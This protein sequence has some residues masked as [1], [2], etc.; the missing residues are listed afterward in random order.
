MDGR[1]MENQIGILSNSASPLFSIDT[2]IQKL[3]V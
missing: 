3:N 2:I 1:S